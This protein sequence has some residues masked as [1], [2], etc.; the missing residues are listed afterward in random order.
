MDD[1]IPKFH[2]GTHYSSSGSVLF[3]LIRTEPFTTQFLQLQGGKFDHADRMY[4]SIPKCWKNVLTGPADVKELI[5]EFY[6]FPDFLKNQNGI[7]LGRL[8]NGGHLNDVQLPGWASTPEEFIRIH[9]QA[10]ESDYVSLHLH[11]WIDLIFGYKQR[12][13]EAE[14]AFNVFYYLTY[15]GAVDLESIEDEG[16]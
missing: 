10:L 16:F 1:T 7:Q 6:Y 13:K 9:R 2:Y 4:D 14:D 11:E 8:Q 5:P 3:Y 12:G 15:E